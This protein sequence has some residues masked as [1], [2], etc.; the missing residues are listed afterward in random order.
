MTIER[1]TEVIKIKLLSILGKLVTTLINGISE[2]L[3]D[4]LDY[5]KDWKTINNLTKHRNVPECK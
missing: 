5:S 1:Y 2:N 3:C 4:C